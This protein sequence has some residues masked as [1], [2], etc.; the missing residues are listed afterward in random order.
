M[1]LFIPYDSAFADLLA[2]DLELWLHEHDYFGLGLWPSLNA[3]LAADR[4]DHRPE[5]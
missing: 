2:S 3:A 5:H 1:E 4:R